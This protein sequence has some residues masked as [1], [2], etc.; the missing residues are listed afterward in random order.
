MRSVHIQRPSTDDEI[1][2]DQ[3]KPAAIPW[4]VAMRSDN[5]QSVA[6]ATKFRNSADP[7]ANCC[8]KALTLRLQQL[9]AAPPIV[10]SQTLIGTYFIPTR[11]T[12]WMVTATDITNTLKT[13]SK[14]Q[15][16]ERFN[17]SPADISSHSL[18]AGGVMALHLNKVPDRTIQILGRWSSDTFL[19]YIHQQIAAFSYTLSTLM[20]TNIIYHNTHINPTLRT[21]G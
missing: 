5:T 11:P 8:L 6:W 19:I 21:I 12:G 18:R 13:A 3:L 10:D 2:R 20:S 1:L 4:S 15:G 17:I 9:Q 7:K 14:A 16:L